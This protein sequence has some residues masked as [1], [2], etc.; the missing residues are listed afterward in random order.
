MNT[1]H[2]V[3]GILA[4]VASRAGAEQHHPLEAITI[5]LSECGSKALQDW[6]VNR[7]ARHRILGV[8]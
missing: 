8:R 2:V 3:I 5:K 4:G 7:R 1:A 6:I